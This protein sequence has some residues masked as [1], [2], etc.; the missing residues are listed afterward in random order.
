[1]FLGKPEE[2]DSATT[3]FIVEKQQK[4]AWNFSLD[5]LNV[6]INANYHSNANHYVEN[7]IIYYIEV[8]TLFSFF[9]VTST[10]VGISSKTFTVLV[11]NLLSHCCKISRLY[12]VSVRN[13]WTWTKA[14]PQES[15]FSSQI[16]IKW[17]YDNFSHTNAR[18]TKLWSHEQIYN[19]IWFTW[20]NFLYEV[21][22]INY[23]VI[24]FISKYLYFKM[25]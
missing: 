15:L 22:D 20:K 2:R 16:F 9:S 4:T 11:L 21:I 24:I 3:F 1:M 8:L 5:S 12:L 7:E 25:S 13:Y 10:N 23:D 14:T 17:G 6:M 19:I 18:V